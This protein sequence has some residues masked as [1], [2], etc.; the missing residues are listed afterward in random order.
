MV[1]ADDRL[2]KEFGNITLPVLILHGTADK[3]TRPAGSQLFYDSAGST[4][5]TI[6]LYDGAFHDPL[7]DL[8]KETVMADIKAWVE[9]RL[10]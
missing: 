4:D 6:K 10:V 7:N 3:A 2:K 8:G 5:R 9:K 1:R